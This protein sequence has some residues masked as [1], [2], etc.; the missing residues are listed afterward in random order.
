MTRLHH[1]FILLTRRDTSRF[2]SLNMYSVLFTLSFYI[3]LLSPPAIAATNVVVN[4]RIAVVTP[5]AQ[6][7]PR[8]DSTCPA[9]ASLCPDGNG[10]CEIGYACTTVT[11]DP[12]CDKP[13]GIGYTTCAGGGCCEPGHRCGGDGLCTS[14][15]P[16]FT[17]PKLSL[18]TLTA[19][20]RSSET[21]ESTETL[22]TT[23]PVETTETVRATETT[24]GVDRNPQ[25]LPTAAGATGGGTPYGKHLNPMT[26]IFG[27]L[28][29]FL[30]ILI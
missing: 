5:P 16:A 13:C 3:I 1:L 20:G 7:I 27:V 8:Q 22:E 10:C 23:D 28:L 30:G 25:P 24:Q 17:I 12:R 6:L 19:A 14:T 11:G 29:G 18:P 9:T 2:R 15:G 26:E 4:N 21:L